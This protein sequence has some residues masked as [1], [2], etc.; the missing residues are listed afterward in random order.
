MNSTKTPTFLAVPLE[1]KNLLEASAGTGKT[2]TVALLYL[3]ALLG[4]GT[5]QNTPLNVD[6]ILVVTFTN[7]ATEELIGRIRNRIK[8]AL[9]FIDNPPEDEPLCAVLEA[10]YRLHNM[11]KEKCRRLL[12]I[13]LSEFGRSHISTIHSFCCEILKLVALDSGLPL[14]I[15]LSIDSEQIDQSINDIWRKNIGKGDAY[16]QS[17][18]RDHLS[19]DG[20]YRKALSKKLDRIQMPEFGLLHD[21]FFAS[22]PDREELEVFFETYQSIF[23][24]PYNQKKTVTAKLDELYAVRPGDC[25]I[26]PKL[27]KFFALTALSAD[28]S[29]KVK[30]DEQLKSALISDAARI[31][32]FMLA[33]KFQNYRKHSIP[34]VNFTFFYDSYKSLVERVDSQE[35]ASGN[36]FS[37]RLIQLA[38]DVSQDARVSRL[39]R[40]KLP[41]AIIDEFQ[42]TDPF[43]YCLFDNIYDGPGCGLLMVGDPKQAIYAFRGG[44]IHTYL[45]AKSSVKN[46]YDLESNFRS[47]DQLVAGINAI[48]SQP[49]SEDHIHYQKGPFNQEHIEFLEISAKANKPLLQVESGGKLKFLCAVHGE[50]LDVNSDCS[51]NAHARRR[52]ISESCANYVSGLLALAGKGRCQL[53]DS[54]TDST[55]G[56]PLKR[57]DIALLVNSHA[58]AKQLKIALLE[59]GIPSLTNTRESIYQ[60]QEAYD[61]WLILRSMLEPTNQR[62][63]ESAL[64]AEINGLGYQKVYGLINDEYGLQKWITEIHELHECLITQGPLVAM[65]RW[66]NLV[67]ANQSFMQMEN[68]RK[69]T[70]VIQLLE[71]LQEDFVL[72]GG[73]QKLFTRFERAIARNDEADEN[74]LRLESDEDRVKIVTIHASKGLEYPVVLVPFAW[75]E[76]SFRPGTLYSAHNDA[77]DVV[78]GFDECIKNLYKQEVIDEKLRQFYVALTRASRHLVL[79]FIDSGGTTKANGF[80]PSKSYNQSPL[81][82]YFP[83][84]ND[85]GSVQLAH[86]DFLRSLNAANSG[87]ITLDECD[88]PAFDAPISVE[89]QPAVTRKGKEFSGEIDSRIGTTSFSKIAHGYSAVLKDD[90]DEGGGGFSQLQLGKPIGR[91]ALAKGANIGTALHNVLEFTDFT[92]WTGTVQESDESTLFSLVQRELKANGVIVDSDE[93]AVEAP[94]YCQWIV[95]V[96]NTPFLNLPGSQGVALKDLTDWYPELTFTF[97]LDRRF[98]KTGLRNFLASAGYNLSGLSGASIYGMLNGAIDL[99]FLHDGKYYLAD[100]KS[101]LLGQDYS[102]YSFES[103]SAS[104]DK[105]AY[106][107]QYLIYTVAL[108]KHLSERID[109]YDYETHFGGV[110]YLY[111]RGMHPE[112]DS[113]GVFF[114]L[115]S[116]SA[117]DGLSEFFSPSLENKAANAEDFEGES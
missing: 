17:V 19:H 27:I 62:Y 36:I 90:D 107:L 58:E 50:Y 73:G 63:F 94:K 40:E 64:L 2:Y 81:G 75:S 79:F 26:A 112:Q 114:H 13:A 45:K 74:L 92:R 84:G 115:P 43:Q 57:G 56:A 32:F 48:F 72:H 69:A 38:A 25:Q 89:S 12:K 78:F 106:T 77:G 85:S 22:R 61:C 108:H 109:G 46:S 97:S 93:L 9:I 113:S 37:D 101:N 55:G 91:H 65:T 104:N 39:I 116:K 47:A 98:S 88:V 6:Q 21:T 111:L 95:E 30:A 54:K 11:D 15:S 42:D 76:P 67:G 96:I 35:S 80:E 10:A 3:R 105:K 70:N 44:D 7:A 34:I 103:L 102:F 99:I 100:Y 68:D 20:I 14:S 117:V 8:E 87:S 16:Y 41:L 5:S 18:V 59:K 4:V 110:F 53:L 28:S 83:T 82:W 23:K 51:L 1:H 33:D 86:A 52:A 49:K 66:F 29:I 71:L 60:E 31:P 24:A